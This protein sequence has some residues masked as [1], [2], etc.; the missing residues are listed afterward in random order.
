MGY[1]FLDY[2]HFH[3]KTVPETVESVNNVISGIINQSGRQCG[4]FGGETNI[5][6]TIPEI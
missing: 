1:E 4:H 3:K 5:D 2:E 6:N